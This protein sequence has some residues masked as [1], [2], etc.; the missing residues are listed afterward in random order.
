MPP[1]FTLFGQSPGIVLLARHYLH[2]LAWGLFPNFIMIALLELMIGLGRG[3]TILIFTMLSVL[4]TIGFSFIFIF[5]K[6]GFPALGIAGAGWGITASS[7]VM[8]ILLGSFVWLNSQYR[9]YFQPA[10]SLAFKWPA[11]SLWVELLKVGLPIGA[12]Y[13]LEV[14]FFFALTLIMGALGGSLWLAANQITMQY[15]CTLM[16]VIFS[17]AQAITVR[18]GHLLGAQEPLAARRAA[19]CGVG[20]AGTF[21]GL[22][23]LLFWCC[24]TLLIAVDF[25]IHRVDAAALIGITITLFRVSALFQIVESIRIAWFGA[26]RSLKDTR[27]PLLSSLVG[28]WLVPLPLGY[29]LARVTSLGAAGLWWGMF[30]GALISAGLL[31]YRFRY[32]MKQVIAQKTQI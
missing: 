10:L 29:A 15:M 24:P 9:G 12:M 31:S 14:A 3:R 16:A 6:L 30:C 1:I 28:F 20:T 26:L 8:V 4:L 23:A 19:F 25:H 11:F 17:I 13:C 7:S 18:M 5:G 32:K 2:A 22:A 21:M 27:F